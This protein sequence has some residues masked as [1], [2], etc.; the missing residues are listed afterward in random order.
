[1]PQVACRLDRNDKLSGI[2]RAAFLALVFGQGTD[3][4][5]FLTLVCKILSDAELMANFD[6]TY[7]FLRF[8]K[9][10]PWR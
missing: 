3:P 5:P 2:A 10:D 4:A 7:L 1:M 9:I 6:Q 8:A